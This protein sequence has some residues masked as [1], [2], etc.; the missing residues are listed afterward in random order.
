ML[1]NLIC[2]EDVCYD[3]NG[4]DY[5]D[6][7]PLKEIKERGAATYDPALAKEYFEKALSAVT[8]GSGNIRGASAGE[9]K[10]G[11]T[12]SF[13]TDGKLPLQLVRTRRVLRRGLHGADHQN[14][15]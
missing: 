9:V 5:T 13:Q 15:P 1:T 11:R 6:Y 2:P 8:D 10:M 14:E 3:E 12:F 4:I 7:A